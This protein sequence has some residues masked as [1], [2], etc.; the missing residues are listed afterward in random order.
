MKGFVG[1]GEQLSFTRTFALPAANTI[2]SLWRPE[3]TKQKQTLQEGEYFEGFI[4][5]KPSKK[6]ITNHL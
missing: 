6:S 1:I 5:T 2:L 4:V 3:S